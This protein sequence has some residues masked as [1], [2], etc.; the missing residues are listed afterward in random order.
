MAPIGPDDLFTV[1]EVAA[2]LKMPLR[3]V[4]QLIRVGTL[5]GH[6][7]GGMR[8][9]RITRQDFEQFLRDELKPIT[10][11]GKSVG[12]LDDDPETYTTFHA[13]DAHDGTPWDPNAF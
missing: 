10:P 3:S 6:T 13:R 7:V 1:K 8:S 12:E 5:R 9:I 4:Y 11:V 2:K